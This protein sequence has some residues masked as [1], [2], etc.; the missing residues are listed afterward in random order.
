[1]AVSSP[2]PFLFLKAKHLF[3][4]DQTFFPPKCKP[5]LLYLLWDKSLHNQLCLVLFLFYLL[6]DICS[7]ILKRCLVIVCIQDLSSKPNA[8][9]ALSSGSI[10]TVYRLSHFR[11]WS[12]L[13]ICLQDSL[14]FPVQSHDKNALAASPQTNNCHCQ[15][16]IHLYSPFFY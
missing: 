13:C 1:M 5:I 2:I 16:T 3:L 11:S 6:M 14:Q 8:F 15:T 9:P 10:I 7:R 4:S 12:E